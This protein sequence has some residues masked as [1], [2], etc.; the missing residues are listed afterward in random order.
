MENLFP[1]PKLDLDNG[2]TV[3]LYMHIY[4]LLL[5]SIMSV[6]LLLHITRKTLRFCAFCLPVTT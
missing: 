5:R 1:A 2:G 6:N 3:E 4:T